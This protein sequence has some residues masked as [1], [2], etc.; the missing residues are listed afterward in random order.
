MTARALV[1]L[2]ILLLAARPVRAQAWVAPAGMGS[3][4]V[5]GQRIANT[6]HFIDDGGRLEVGLSTDASLYFEGEY[7]VTDRLSVSAGLPY[8]LARYTSPEPTPINFLPV[9]SCRCWHGGWQD[10]GVR[11]RYNLIGGG[12]AL[13]PSVAFGVPS[14]AYNYRGEAVIGRQLKEVR[15]GVDAGQRLD[16]LSSRLSLQGSYSYA[17]VERTLDVANNRSN[18]GV[19][20]AVAVTRRLS[21]RWLSSWQRTHGGLR[22]P[23]DLSTDDLITQHDRLLRDDYWHTGFGASYS[24]PQLDFFASYIAYARGTNSH[25]GRVITAG[26]SWPFEITRA[27]RP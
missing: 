12:F 21:A 24:L 6:G 27:N 7:A 8:V 2:P 9:D 3:I 16:A 17:L 1:I 22:F 5:A 19:E 13:T 11:A 10:F 20:V 14:H 4:S 18:A 15:F 26:I 23:Q 25:A